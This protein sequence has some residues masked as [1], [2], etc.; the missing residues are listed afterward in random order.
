MLTNEYYIQC[1]FL[2]NISVDHYTI[3]V[4]AHHAES[5]TVTILVS[6]VSRYMYIVCMYVCRYVCMYVCMYKWNI[7][8]SDENIQV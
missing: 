3:T 6:S 4:W 5:V 1:D 8:A 7:C 2:K